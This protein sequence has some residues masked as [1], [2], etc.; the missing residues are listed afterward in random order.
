M[1]L[2]QQMSVLLGRAMFDRVAGEAGA[3]A[4]LFAV[5]KPYYSA[6]N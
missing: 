5:N 3:Q 2:W 6:S 4:S 1:S